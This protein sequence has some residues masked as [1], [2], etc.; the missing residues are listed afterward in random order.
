MV[1]RAWSDCLAHVQRCVE[2]YAGG[3]D[4]PAAEPIALFKRYRP[5]LGVVEPQAQQMP[6][7]FGLGPVL[8]I[9]SGVQGDVVVEELYVSGLKGN[10][11][12]ELFGDFPIE[13]D[14]L[15]LC[16]APGKHTGQ[17]LGLVDGRAG[18]DGAE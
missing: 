10:I 16:G 3:Q 17:T 9:A 8:V 12:Q 18:T 1:V 5:A 14:R 7:A 11:Q 2:L 15:L 6:L 4:A 13:R